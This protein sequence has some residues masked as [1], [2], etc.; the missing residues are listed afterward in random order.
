M[1]QE[2]VIYAI[3]VIIG[4]ILASLLTHHWRRDGRGWNLGTW[5]TAAWVMTAADLLFALRPRLP[6]W[7]GRTAPTLLVTVGEVVLLLWA[8]RI[9]GRHSSARLAATIVAAHALALA[10][11]L[12]ID[13]I[14]GWRSVFNG[15]LWGGISIAASAYLRRA[16]QASRS[17][18]S[19][20]AAILLAH[21]LFHAFRVAF[22]A[23][24]ASS[25]DTG[26]GPWVQLMGDVEV[27]VY[28]VALFVSLLVAHL[29]LRNEELRA[30]LHDVQLLSTLLPICAWCRKV[31][32]DDGYWQQLE[33]YFASRRQVQFTHG[34]CESCNAEHFGTTTIG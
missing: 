18:M 21:G 6:Y 2:Q 13:G 23:V 19:I 24:V 34:I 20:P 27:S 8:R 11:F 10:A 1:Y 26:A 22:A 5:M 3:N 32:A 28:M 29:Q 7:V 17:A 9:A 16:P 33:H 15:V 30:A 25:G 31:R 14:A 4:A 12:M